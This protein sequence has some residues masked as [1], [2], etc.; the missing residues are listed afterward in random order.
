MRPLALL[1]AL[2]GCLVTA[3][4]S[5]QA[6][7][8]DLPVYRR[9]EPRSSGVAYALAIGGT[10]APMYAAKAVDGSGSG[11]S[12][13]VPALIGAGICWGPSLGFGY[14]RAWRTALVSGLAKSALLGGAML[15]DE[16]TLPDDPDDGGHAYAT[17]LAGAAVFIWSVVDIVRLDGVVDRENAEADRQ[18]HP[19]LA[20]AP[21]VWLGGKL[22]AAG[23]SGRF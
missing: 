4:A 9:P 23:V 8:P 13:A 18:A 21:Y 6:P 16:R 20:L 15:L 10:L 22:S 2:I 11:S 14:A 17:T 12:R 3:S 1:V 7:G 19:G 5:A